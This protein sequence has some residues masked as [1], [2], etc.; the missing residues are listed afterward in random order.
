MLGVTERPRQPL[1]EAVLDHLA[2]RRSLLVLD[3]CDHLLGVAA[4]FAERLLAAC[5][6]V[7]V[8]ATSRERLAVAGERTVP[9]PPL[10]LVADVAGSE[11]GS[12]ASVLFIDRARAVGAD[13]IPA[14]A[15]NERLAPSS[16]ACRW[17]SSWPQRAARRWGWTACSP[18]WTTTCGCWRAAAALIHGTTRCAPSSAGATTCSTNPNAPCSAA[19]ACSPAGSTWMRPKPSAQPRSAGPSPT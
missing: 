10:S 11:A 16:T 2:A 15:V 7:T 17:R 8:L 19:S 12:E 13:F 4:A 18:A 6:G 5:P 1:E 3:N 9:V 14:T